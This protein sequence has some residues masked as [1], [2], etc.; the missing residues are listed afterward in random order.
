MN[1]PVA[2][3]PIAEMTASRGLADALQAE[4]RSAP[5]YTA[6]AAIHCLLFLLLM[7][8]PAPQPQPQRVIII[9]EVKFKEDEPPPE[10]SEVVKDIPQLLEP[11]ENNIE[12]LQEIDLPLLISEPCEIAENLTTD[13]DMPCEEAKGDPNNLSQ[14]DDDCTGQICLMGVDGN[15]GR[16]PG[17]GPYGKRLGDGGDKIRRGQQVG[18]PASAIQR[19]DS[20]L[21]WL[22]EHQEANG[23]WLN[24]KY[25]GGGHAAQDVA[26]TSLALLA[27]LGAGNT[28]NFGRYKKNVAAA[29]SWLKQQENPPGSGCIGPHR[30]EAG[31]ALMALAE[32]YGMSTATGKSDQE[33]RGLLQRMVKWG[34]AAQCPAGGWNYTPHAPRVDTSVSGW[35]VMG[36]KAAKFAGLEVSYEVFEKALKYFQK[37]TA[38]QADG[39]YAGASVSYA[40]DNAATV[41]QVQAG[42]GSSRLTAVALTCLQFLGRPRD[43]QQVMACARQIL[44]DG[45]PAMANYDFYRWYYAALGLFQLGS[46]SEPW[47]AWCKPL[48][49]V[50][51]DTQV[52][53]GTYKENRGSWNYERDPWGSA[54]GRVGQTALGALMLETAWRY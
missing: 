14:F 22:A 10:E 2:L 18:V 29:V 6:S 48:I 4:L 26:V 13:N 40:T 44:R 17:A 47:R 21:R 24:Q 23:Q 42:G 36:M 46:R 16:A 11:S 53:E 35:W 51:L 50:L 25:G 39:E 20:A 41:E 33:L 34:A 9:G 28:M 37:A 30:Y 19:L 12:A 5:W 38:L 27:F 49:S 8:M 1:T 3:L 15:S 54:W 7:F 43:D 32:A 52:K 31:I 45:V